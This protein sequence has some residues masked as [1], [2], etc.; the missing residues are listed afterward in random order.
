MNLVLCLEISEVQENCGGGCRHGT[1]RLE[2]DK[3]LLIVTEETASEAVELGSIR[4]LGGRTATSRKEERCLCSTWPAHVNISQGTRNKTRCP[5]VIGT[6]QVGAVI[7]YSLLLADELTVKVNA[8]RAQIR[9][10]S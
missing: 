4:E 7:K 10:E 3:N 2:T 9:A 6:D 1:K 8:I 5:L